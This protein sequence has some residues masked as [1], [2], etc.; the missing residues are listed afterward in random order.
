MSFKDLDFHDRPTA[1]CNREGY[2]YFHPVVCSSSFFFIFLA[3]QL[4]QI[5]CLPYYHTWCGLS[6]NLGCR[7][8]TCCTRLVENTGRKKIAKNSPS[9]HHRTNLSVYIFPT[10]ALIVIDNGKNLFSSNISSTCPHIMVNFGPL[11]A[12][13]GPFGASQ[14]ISTAFASWLRYCSDVAQRKPTKL[15]TMFGRLLGCYAIY[16]FRGLLLPDG[17]LPRAKFT[18][19]LD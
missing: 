2:I 9:V 14:L 1:L 16:T 19:I 10:E 11:A 12:E 13:I 17:N 8:E 7:S 5:G 18:S 6:A 3:P 15:C 4:S